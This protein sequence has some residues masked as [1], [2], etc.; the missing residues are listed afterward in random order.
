M[1]I[2][3]ICDRFLLRCDFKV[4]ESETVLAQFLYDDSENII[5]NQYDS[6]NNV[7]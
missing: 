6:R 4:E 1:S 5:H 3:F 2:Y 7:S